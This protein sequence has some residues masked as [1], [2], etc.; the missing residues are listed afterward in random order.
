VLKKK[1]NSIAFHF[2]HECSA[3]DIIHVAYEPTNT[4]LADI[5]TKTQAGPKRR[6]LCAK[7]L[8]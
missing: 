6:E 2:V 4:N 1:S 7:I 3:A 8:Y 5:C